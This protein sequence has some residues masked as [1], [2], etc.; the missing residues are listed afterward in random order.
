[1]KSRSRR[2]AIAATLVSVNHFVGSLGP[3][4]E[5][6][7][8]WRL[9]EPDLLT[10]S[11]RVRISHGPHVPQANPCAHSCAVISR[12]WIRK[13]PPRFRARASM[14]PRVRPCELDVLSLPGSAFGRC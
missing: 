10:T 9:R 5:P 14:A 4:R 8:R 6:R 13:T 2:R 12:V 11:P 7:A 1:M 3:F